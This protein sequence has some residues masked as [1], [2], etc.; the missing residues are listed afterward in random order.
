[1]E[2][3]FR[4]TAPKTLTSNRQLLSKSYCRWTC[5]STYCTP[6]N[7]SML[8]CSSWPRCEPDVLPKSFPLHPSIPVPQ[9]IVGEWCGFGVQLKYL[10]VC[11]ASSNLCHC[12]NSWDSKCKQNQ[13]LGS[14][15]VQVRLMYISIINW[16]LC[17]LVSFSQTPWLDCM[18]NKIWNWVWFT[19]KW[20]WTCYLSMQSHGKP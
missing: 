11:P 7:G 1:M 14:L 6:W 10:L 9:L 20:Y 3:S 13:K 18:D 12:V 5:S 19:N 17:K 15:F 4:I 8:S 2:V 16:K